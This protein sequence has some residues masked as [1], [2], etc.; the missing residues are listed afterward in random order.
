[1]NPN[2]VISSRD[3]ERLESLADSLPASEAHARDALLHEL[4]RA[5]VVEPDA[6]PPSIVAMNSTVRF[7]IESSGDEHELTLVYPHD[8][9]KR[10]GTISILSP[11]GTA[12]LGM[13]AGKMIKWPRPDGELVEVRILGIVNPC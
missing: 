3:L 12:L 9:G 11:I 5:E 13:A 7:S 10:D 4:S 2:I 6:L 8:M 1:M